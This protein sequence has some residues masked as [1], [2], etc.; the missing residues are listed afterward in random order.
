MDFQGG[1]P[2][3]GETEL[4]DVENTVRAREHARRQKQSVG[5]ICFEVGRSIHD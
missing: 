2:D 5:A 3:L 1:F 4:E